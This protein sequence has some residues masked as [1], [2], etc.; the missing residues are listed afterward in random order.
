LKLLNSL[1]GEKE[2]TE[3]VK[4]STGATPHPS[5]AHPATVPT[6][7]VDPKNLDT[8]RNRML[9]ERAD[10]P[11]VAVAAHLEYTADDEILTPEQK[12]QRELETQKKL[13]EDKEKTEKKLAAK[14]QERAKAKAETL[15]KIGEIL[16]EHNNN[17]SEIPP[18]SEYW[19]LVAQ[20]R[21]T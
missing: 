14:D 18:S 19:A 16:K 6:K 1:E 4:P 20:Y 15:K 10:H 8:L 13:R 11:V 12:A 3:S 5:T 9:K 21:T 2:M 17:E 7:E